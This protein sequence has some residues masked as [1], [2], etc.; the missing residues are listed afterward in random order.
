MMAF[1]KRND[2]FKEEV[3]G[4]AAFTQPTNVS[5]CAK[6]K[7]N[8]CHRWDVSNTMS[9][10]MS[11]SSHMVSSFRPNDTKFLTHRKLYICATYIIIFELFI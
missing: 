9:E 10:K 6:I 5:N 3:R 7:K 8:T 11:K 4:S 2:E 1:C